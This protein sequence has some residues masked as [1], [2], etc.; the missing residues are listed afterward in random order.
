ML[1]IN[2]IQLSPGF[3]RDPLEDSVGLINDGEQS[4]LEKNMSLGRNV[5][6]N[7]LDET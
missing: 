2:G 4:N 5:F 3:G 1:K 6:L 7:E